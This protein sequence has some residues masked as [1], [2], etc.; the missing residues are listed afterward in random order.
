MSLHGRI[1]HVFD[2]VQAGEGWAELSEVPLTVMCCGQWLVFL[3][4]AKGYMPVPESPWTQIP[5]LFWPLPPVL[6]SALARS[7]TELSLLGL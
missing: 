7:F 2:H 5:S 1:F 6:V 4:G 3:C